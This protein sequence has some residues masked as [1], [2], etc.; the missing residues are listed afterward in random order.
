MIWNHQVKKF[1]FN[2]LFSDFKDKNI[3]INTEGRNI[4]VQGGNNQSSGNQGNNNGKNFIE[5]QKEAYAT[6]I[7]QS[8]TEHATKSWYEKCICGL[9]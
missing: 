9:E 3:Q 4:Q 7:V 1:N 8:A 5:R 6:S 2:L